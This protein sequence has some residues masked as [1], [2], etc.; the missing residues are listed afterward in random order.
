MLLFLTVVGPP[1][2]CS[3]ELIVNGGFEAGN[4]TGWSQEE[5]T[6]DTFVSRYGAHTGEYDLLAGPNSTGYLIQAVTLDTRRAYRL[7]FW[8]Y[9]YDGG[10]TS[11][12]FSLALQPP[13]AWLTVLPPQGDGPALA[14]APLGL[15]DY[16]PGIPWT[17]YEL[18][19]QPAA[20]ATQLRFAYYSDRRTGWPW[21]LDDV[22]LGALPCARDADCGSPALLCSDA[23]CT[24]CSTL[25]LSGNW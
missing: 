21:E 11:N 25:T 6:A 14:G 13:P 1:A 23:L 8:L 22:S 5:N 19:F 7:S 2:P 12:S 20:S 10:E 24:P 4:L 15:V 17:R 18:R 16:G 9:K 3:P